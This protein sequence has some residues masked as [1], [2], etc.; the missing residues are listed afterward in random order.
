MC[1]L[2]NHLT[3]R[4]ARF[5]KGLTSLNTLYI[6]LFS[7]HVKD[8]SLFFKQI[9]DYLFFFFYH[10]EKSLFIKEFD[11]LHECTCSTQNGWEEIINRGWIAKISQLQSS[12]TAADNNFCIDIFYL[13]S[14]K[15][16]F[17]FLR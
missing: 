14:Y 7:P 15:N 11:N 12:T 13:F 16:R 17:F 3:S 2:G 5:L 6:S 8:I 1:I 10:Q 4:S 9:F